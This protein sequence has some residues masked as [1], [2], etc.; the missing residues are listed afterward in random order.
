MPLRYYLYKYHFLFWHHLVMLLYALTKWVDARR[1][2][3][4]HAYERCLDE[5]KAE[6]I[7]K[8]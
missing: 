1:E 6:L 2:V 5:V 4:V 3:T 8:E 7:E